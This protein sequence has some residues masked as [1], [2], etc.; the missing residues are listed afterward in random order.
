MAAEIPKVVSCECGWEAR[1]ND[2]E[3]VR[4]VQDHGR[5]EHRMDVSPEQ[6]LAMAK[7]LV[8]E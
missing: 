5:S 1:G 6:A 7:P 8:S 2:D 3:I 4:A